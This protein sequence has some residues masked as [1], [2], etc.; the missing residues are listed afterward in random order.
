MENFRC[1]VCDT[2]G[3]WENVDEFRLK[4]ENM[5]MCKNCGFVT[6]PS[7]YKTEEEI[8]EYYREDY[9]QPP[10][11]GNLY[12]GQ[13]KLNYHSAFLNDLLREWKEKERKDLVV[14][15]VGAAYGLFLNWIKR[16]FPEADINGTELTKS[17][18]R[19]AWHEFGIALTEDF[20]YSKKY[21]LIASYKVAEHIMDI[22]KQLRKQV[23]CL[24]DDGLFYISVPTWFNRLS[25]FGVSGFDI[26]Y[27]YH[28][29]HINV[30]TRDQFEVL[31]KKVGLEIIKED[32]AMY[33]NTYLCKRNDELMKEEFDYGNPNVTKK[34]LER[35]KAAALFVLDGK[36]EEAVNAWPDFPHAHTGLYETKRKE[37]HEK[38]FEWIEKNFMNKVLSLCHDSSE[39][40]GLC[41]NICMRYDQWEKALE[42]FSKG[43]EVRPG[44]PPF[45]SS[46]SQC[47]RQMSERESNPENKIKLRLE[48]RDSAKYLLEVSKQSEAE[49]LN[50]I[51]IDNAQ[52]PMPN[53]AN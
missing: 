16:N 4:P 25:N 52:L 9:R 50:W 26:E 14:G 24:K 41:G 29:N 20:D 23:E 10:T 36:F 53:E 32:H 2:V 13:R 48:A 6:Y 40:L 35:I 22:D 5:C 47:F 45:L 7:Q 12:S 30:W 31:L 44:S 28:T 3:Q 38:G 34:N 21:D 39:I 27:Y 42:F 43:L 49:A 37:F 17:Y 15:E 19:N 11:A 33:D 1:L 8:K 18:R 51:Y 46:L